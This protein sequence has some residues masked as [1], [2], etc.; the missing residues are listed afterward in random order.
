MENREY[1]I[2]EV[3]ILGGN[4]KGEIKFILFL[5]FSQINKLVLEGFYYN[6]GKVRSIPAKIGGTTWMSSFP[7]E[8]RVVE[9]LNELLN[10]ELDDVSLA[11]ELL[12]YVMKRQIFIDGNKRTAVIFANHHLISRGLG[13]IS[14]PGDLVEDYKEMLIMYYEEKDTNKIKQ[15]LKDKCYVSLKR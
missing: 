6:A 12:L 15:F 11:I 1:S 9:E 5:L 13:I 3:G 8:S 2:C 10:S 14:I 7:I 4:D